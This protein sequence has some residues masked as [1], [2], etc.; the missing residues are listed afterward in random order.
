MY[1]KEYT[2]LQQIIYVLIHHFH[3]IEER[4]YKKISKWLNQSG[5]MTLRGIN[6]AA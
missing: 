4:D 1:Q 3:D 5:I 6:G 2:I